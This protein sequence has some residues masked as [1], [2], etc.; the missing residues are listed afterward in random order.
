VRLCIYKSRLQRLTG[1]R[2]RAPSIRHFS[3]FSDK[4]AD[5]ELTERSRNMTA[6]AWLS[7]LFRPVSPLG[8]SFVNYFRVFRT[9]GTIR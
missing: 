3:T 1:K 7:K 2:Q 6:T 9:S 4:R 5:L 8:F